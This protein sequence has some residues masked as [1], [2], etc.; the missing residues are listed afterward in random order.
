M[1]PSPQHSPMLCVPKVIFWT[2]IAAGFTASVLLKHV[3]SWLSDLNTKNQKVVEKTDSQDVGLFSSTINIG[4][5]S[6]CT[7]ETTS[8]DKPEAPDICLFGNAVSEARTSKSVIVSL[9]AVIL[10]LL[11]L[12]ILEFSSKSTDEVSLHIHYTGVGIYRPVADLF[13]DLSKQLSSLM[14]GFPPDKKFPS[15][16]LKEL[17]AGRSSGGLRHPRYFGPDFLILLVL[18][19]CCRS[20]GTTSLWPSVYFAL[21]IYKEIPFGIPNFVF[22]LGLQT[23]TTLLRHVVCKYIGSRGGSFRLKTTSVSI[24]TMNPDTNPEMEDAKSR[25]ALCQTSA[26]SF[27][28]SFILI[29]QEQPGQSHDTAA[30]FV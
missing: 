7:V 8:S 28:S 4:T 24:W 3:E 21:T 26:G 27:C 6:P 10:I 20:A 1:H 11:I 15:G 13:D 22:L 19:I 29:Q 17:W 9:P 2:V 25:G 14:N 23:Q 12:D 30:G 16:L 18:G 5:A